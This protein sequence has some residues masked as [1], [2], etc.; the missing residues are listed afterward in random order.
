MNNLKNI[1]KLAKVIRELHRCNKL[2]RWQ[3]FTNKIRVFFKYKPIENVVLDPERRKVLE[4][5][6]A[7]ITKRINESK[8]NT[9]LNN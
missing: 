4:K 9:T 6:V 3:R 8:N 2:S 7:K 5:K 1:K